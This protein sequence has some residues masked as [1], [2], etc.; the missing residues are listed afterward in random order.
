[1]FPKGC[2]GRW[3]SQENYFHQHF[4]S[5]DHHG[6]L[7]DCEITLVDKSDSSDPTRRVYFWMFE[8]K[9]FAPVGLNIC[10]IV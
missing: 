9:T 7:K 3:Y 4:L 6:L 1:M 5:E 8:V 2:I 10:D